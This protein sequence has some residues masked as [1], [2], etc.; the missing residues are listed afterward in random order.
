MRWW[1]HWLKRVE[2]GIMDKPKL[3]LWV[4]DAV[5]PRSF[6]VTRP[7]R[8]VSE[9]AWPSSNVVARR[10]HFGAGTLVEAPS[11]V[12]AETGYEWRSAEAA[13]ADSGP[14]CG[15]GGPT[16]SP[17]DQRIEDGL[18]LCFTS[19]PLRERIEIVG[20]PSLSVSL[21]SDRARALIAVRLCDVWPDGRS[22]LITRG[23]L[24]LTHRDSHEH[25]ETLEPGR[26]YT[27]EVTMNAIAYAVPAGHRLRVALSPSYWPWA[28]PS[29][30]SVTLSVFTG[31]ESA[32]TLPLRTGGAE[33][34]EPEHFRWPERPPSPPVDTMGSG[35]GDKHEIRRDQ[36]SGLVEI[37]NDL[38]Y[39]RPV[40][41][42]E[43]G[44]EYVDLGRD[45]YRIVEGDP[46]SAATR[47]ERSIAIGRGDWRVRV[48]TVS[49]MSATADDYHVTN[50]LEA[51]EA[52]TRIFAKTWHAVIRRDFT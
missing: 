15:W 42:I 40:R 52:G 29:P 7:G 23:L 50:T 37:V 31:P 34:D 43:S 12:D 8:W 16:D 30:E 49:T 20:F 44:L 1:D 4:Q 25:P 18:S 51:Y 39:F 22:T 14:F 26:R 27:V 36:A 9:P 46:V 24:N 32:L 13:G 28:W 11:I 45:V 33:H 3:R 17:P 6:Y 48:E 38:A 47:S 41:F 5:E 21:A 35:S 2:T 10:L 19:Q